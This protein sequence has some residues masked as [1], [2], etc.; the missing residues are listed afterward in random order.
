[1][2]RRPPRSTLTDTLSPYTTLFRS[3]NT[4]PRH[5]SV[6]PARGSNAI[7]RMRPA[8][9]LRASAV[10]A[11]RGCCGFTL[12]EL[13]VL[14]VIVGLT[15]AA[16]VLTAPDT[17][18]PLV[19]EADNSSA[20]LVPAGEAATPPVRLLLVPVDPHGQAFASPTITP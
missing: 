14:L 12:V 17:R 2:I 18:R 1:M 6:Q 5:R 9:R 11:M 15:G 19:R 20:R 10:V 7:A 16:V 13:M 8:S 3:V 4:R